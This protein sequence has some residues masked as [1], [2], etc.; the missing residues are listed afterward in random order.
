MT[1][2]IQYEITQLNYYISP[3]IIKIILFI[4]LVK[5]CKLKN[6]V[7]TGKFQCDIYAWITK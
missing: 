6:Y 1:V 7:H 5:I 3:L 4:E 2:K